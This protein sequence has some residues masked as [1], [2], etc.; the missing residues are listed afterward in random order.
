MKNLKNSKI[1]I[2]NPLTFNLPRYEGLMEKNKTQDF[3]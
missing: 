3:F 2:S 1:L